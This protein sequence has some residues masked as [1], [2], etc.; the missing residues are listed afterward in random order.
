MLSFFRFRRA[1]PRL[2]TETLL[3]ALCRPL[4]VEFSLCGFAPSLGL[5]IFLSCSPKVSEAAA[6]LR[7]SKPFFVDTFPAQKRPAAFALYS[8]A[9][10][11]APVIGPPLGG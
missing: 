9:I 4:H 3:H 2:R 10:V 6:S 1:K 5:L 7:S 8:M 11:T